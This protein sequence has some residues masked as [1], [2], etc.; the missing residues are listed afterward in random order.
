MLL[1][2]QVLR[3]LCCDR[4]LTLMEA[5]DGAKRIQ[6]SVNSAGRALGAQAWLGLP[7]TAFLISRY[8]LHL[9][10]I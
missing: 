3:S 4:V 1:I 9:H 10:L 5:T 8:H 2:C 7:L 6:F